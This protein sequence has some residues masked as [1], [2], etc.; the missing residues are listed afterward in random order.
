MIRKR[1][2][3]EQI[4]GGAERC[5]SRGQRPSPVSDTRDLGGDVL[6]LADEIR[7]LGRPRREESASAGR[8]T[9]AV[10]ADGSGAGA[11]QRGTEGPHR[12][13]LVR[14]KAKRAAA[15]EVGARVGLSQ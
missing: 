6:Y 13:K 12:H 11:R 5:P 15:Q 14:P 8:R 7:R 4:I 10:E 3:E 9:P 1:H 2:T